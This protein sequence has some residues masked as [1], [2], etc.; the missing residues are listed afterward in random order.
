MRFSRIIHPAPLVPS[1]TQR[2]LVPEEHAPLLTPQH[3]PQRPLKPVVAVMSAFSSGRHRLS[4]GL[5]ASP[6]LPELPEARIYFV[7][8]YLD[9]MPSEGFLHGLDQA[10][11]KGLAVLMASPD[12]GYHDEHHFT[13]VGGRDGFYSADWRQELPTLV[14]RLYVDLRESEFKGNPAKNLIFVGHSKGGLLLHGLAVLARR[15]EANNV[16]ALYDVFPGLHA[17]PAH[18]IQHVGQVLQGARFLAIGSPFDGVGKRVEHLARVTQF[19]RFFGGTSRY[20]NP[21]FLRAHYSQTGFE[22]EEVIDAVLTT[23]PF[24]SDQNLLSAA[25]LAKSALRIANPFRPTIYDGGVS[26]FDV[27]GL[28]ITPDASGDGLVEHSRRGF[29]HSEHFK[30]YNHLTQLDP[31]MARRVIN[32]LREID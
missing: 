20:Y 13:L 16:Q 23:S 25:T 1:G 22:P 30:G 7:P 21:D 8:G 32:L 15:M 3:D 2:L 9:Y 26:L 29:A 10:A 24:S 28:F 12:E 6:R 11:G 4:S 27:A 17:V 14:Q 5:V 31:A 19:D 18:V